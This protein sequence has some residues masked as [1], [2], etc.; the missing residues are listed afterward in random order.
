MSLVPY[1]NDG[2]KD[3]LLPSTVASNARQRYS[4][5]SNAA[6]ETSAC[7][8]GHAPVRNLHSREGTWCLRCGYVYL[9]HR[10]DCACSK[11]ALK[12]ARSYQQFELIM[13]STPLP[14]KRRFTRGVPHVQSAMDGFLLH[15]CLWSDRLRQ[16]I[17]NAGPLTTGCT[18]ARPKSSFC[19]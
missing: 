15:F 12:N 1:Q 8:A 4:T 18:P 17:H 19:D 13:Y 3:M 7:S 9:R 6:G 10:V 2:L 14:I 5:N 16:N 11:L